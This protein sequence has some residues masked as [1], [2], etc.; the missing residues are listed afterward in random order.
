M[1]FEYASSLPYENNFR[2]FLQRLDELFSKYKSDESVLLALTCYAT[3]CLSFVVNE[4]LS[5]INAMQ[6]AM[7]GYL[8]AKNNLPLIG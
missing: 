3:S 4:E 6:S 5:E 1:D 7:D 8:K 2:Y